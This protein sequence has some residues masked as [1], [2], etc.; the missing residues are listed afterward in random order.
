MIF[1]IFYDAFMEIYIFK[2]KFFIEHG[3]HEKNEKFRLFCVFRVLKNI[4]VR[5]NVLI[6][7]LINVSP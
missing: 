2:A 6:H 1:T 5:I 7:V 4:N 3:K